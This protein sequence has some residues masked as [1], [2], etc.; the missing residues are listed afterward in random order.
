VL[1]EKPNKG[2]NTN[3]PTSIADTAVRIRGQA[4]RI[5]PTVPRGF[6]T[7]F[8]VPDTPNVNPAQSGRRSGPIHPAD[9]RHSRLITGLAGLTRGLS[10]CLRQIQTHSLKP[11]TNIMSAAGTAKE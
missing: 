7:T 2:K 9:P 10:R 5:G 3:V 6:L 11:S 4:E 1:I 8:T